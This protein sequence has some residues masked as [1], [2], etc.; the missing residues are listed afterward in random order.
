[1]RKFAPLFLASL[2]LS[3]CGGGGSSPVA[4]LG[5]SP[6]YA[7]TGT[8]TI[9]ATE[10]GGATTPCTADSFSGC[11]T[12][13]WDFRTDGS[14]YVGSASS[15]RYYGTY[16]RAGSKLVF[17]SVTGATQETNFRWVAASEFRESE[18][19]TTWTVWTKL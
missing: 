4:V 6:E 8:W 10:T 12:A 7:L 1:M 3:G 13:R 14:L 9:S 19:G 15:T 11:Q 2:I 17:R 16:E 5:G 18:S